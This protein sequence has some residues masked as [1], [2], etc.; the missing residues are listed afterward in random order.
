VLI[1]FVGVILEGAETGRPLFALEVV[2]EETGAIRADSARL[3][4]TGVSTAFAG[5]SFAAAITLAAETGDAT[6]LLPILLLLV[7]NIS[8]FSTELISGIPE[9]SGVMDSRFIAEGEDVLLASGVPEGL[10]L[11]LPAAPLTGTDGAF[12][13]KVVNDTGNESGTLNECF[14]TH[15]IR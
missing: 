2:G 14:P 8:F 9:G 1:G 5:T 11:P 3:G 15:T 13:R 6:A 4:E 10:E 12:S 7:A